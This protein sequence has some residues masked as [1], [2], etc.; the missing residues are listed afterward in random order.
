MEAFERAVRYNAAHTSEFEKLKYELYELLTAASLERKAPDGGQF[1]LELGGTA[2][3]DVLLVCDS[4]ESLDE[5]LV[6][7]IQSAL[8]SGKYSLDWRVRVSFEN[9]SATI[10][11]TY[12]DRVAYAS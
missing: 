11:T 2:G 6:A 5:S 8:Q 1:Y 7:S 10:Q 4:A 9:D 3:E 12:K